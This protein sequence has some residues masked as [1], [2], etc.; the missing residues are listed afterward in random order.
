MP[1]VPLQTSWPR[2]SQIAGN[3]DWKRVKWFNMSWL[4]D[5]FR[6]GKERTDSPHPSM[7]SCRCHCACL[8]PLTPV[9][10]CNSGYCSIHR[11]SLFAFIIIIGKTSLFEPQPS[12]E[13]SPTFVYRSCGFHFFDFAIIIFLHSKV[14]ISFASNPKP[15]GPGICISVPQ[16]QGSPVITPGTG[17]PFCHLR[18]AGQ[19]WRYYNPPPHSISLHSLLLLVMT[20]RRAVGWRG[21]LLPVFS[22]SLT[23]V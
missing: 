5:K 16:W 2:R 9:V 19:W 1:S 23:K 14:I 13:Y 12:L 17:F 3:Q 10:V 15:G 11:V 22:L 7:P 18:L 21:R 6:L 8:P 4:I 20:V